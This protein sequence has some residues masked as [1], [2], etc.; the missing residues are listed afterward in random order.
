MAGLGLELGR[1]GK[2]TYGKKENQES[3]EESKKRMETGKKRP[4]GPAKSKSR[5]TF[6][7]VPRGNASIFSD[8]A[9]GAYTTV[10]YTDRL[11]CRRLERC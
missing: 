11:V 9:K 1:L 4:Y 7:R 3:K 8:G 6:T 5:E 10:F 2:K